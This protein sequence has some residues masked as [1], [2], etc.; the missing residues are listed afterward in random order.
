MDYINLYNLSFNVKHQIISIEHQDR[1]LTMNINPDKSVTRIPVTSS[2]A[3]VIPPYSI[4]A[5]PVSVPISSI[6]SS[7]IPTNTTSNSS[8]LFISQTFIKFNDY[9]STSNTSSFPRFINEGYY[10]GFLFHRLKPHSLTITPTLNKS[11][12]SAGFAGEST[13]FDALNSH[14]YNAAPTRHSSILVKAFHT[15]YFF[16]NRKPH[17]NSILRCNAAPNDRFAELTNSIKNEKHREDLYSLLVRFFEL[18]D[19]SK[20]NIANTS[21][22]HVI[23]TLPHSPPACKPYPQ[24][25]KE[26]AMYKLIQEFLRVGLISESHSPYAVPAILVKKKDGSLRFVVDYKKLNLIT[27]KDS[28]PLP[29]MENALRKLGRGYSHFSK[30]DLKSGFY[31]IPIKETDKEKTA[32]VT[33]FGLYQFNVLPMGLKNSPPTFQKVMT[34]TLKSCRNFSLVY[35]DDINCLLEIFSRTFI[36]PRTCITST[37]SQKAY[38]KPSEVCFCS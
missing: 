8:S 6:A 32:F 18:F 4:L 2:K 21:I 38:F 3:I 37:A 26:Q 24:P 27:I 36:S 29:N 10:V 14:R 7:L 1:I 22:H 25:D 28:S 23:N 15:R 13:A 9:R 20:H 12:G 33:P 19:T 30:L 31:Q 35:L 17:C 5:V 16:S 34:D 11:S